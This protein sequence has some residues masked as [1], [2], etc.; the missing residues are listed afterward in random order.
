MDVYYQFAAMIGLP[1]GLT[2]FDFGFILIFGI[3]DLFFFF[4][5]SRLMIAVS[6]RG[7]LVAVD[8]LVVRSRSSQPSQLFRGAENLTIR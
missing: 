2:F 7:K 4:W 6:E 1:S 5:S 8:L 3:E